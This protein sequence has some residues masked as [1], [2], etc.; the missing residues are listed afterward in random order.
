M[1][2]R[3]NVA[4]ALSVVLL[5]SVV[6][7]THSKPPPPTS[8]GTG[9][10]AS[11]ITIGST[12]PLSGVAEPG[13]NEIARASESYFKYVNAAG[14]VHGR[15]INYVYADDGGSAAKALRQTREQ[16]SK[17]DV[18]AVFNAF[19]TVTHQAAAA[20]LDAHR[21]PDVFVDSACPC[22][23]SVAA[24]PFSFGFQPQG[25]VEGKILGDYV[26]HFFARKKVGY[27]TASDAAGRD[28]ARGLDAVLPHKR[29][30]ARTTYKQHDIKI[31]AQVRKLQASGAQVVIAASIPLFTALLEINALRLHYH[32]QL[33]VSSASADPTT[34]T[35]LLGIVAR[36]A[37]VTVDAGAVLNRVVT[38]TYLPVPTDTSNA[39]IKLFRR[40]HDTYIP[41]LPFDGNVVYG[42]AAAYSFV[43]ALS[44]A[45]EQ[46]TRA[47][48]VAAIEAGLPQGAGL[49]PFAFSADSHRGYTGAQIAVIHRGRL[50]LVGQPRTTDPGDGAVTTFVGK[51]PD[52]P[53]GGIPAT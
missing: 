49:V 52:P 19:G 42:M 14:G 29:V 9:L 31:A 20:F 5:A 18:F 11:T 21:V 25:I 1:K 2:L 13:Y 30:V 8:T 40:I 53:T 22:W 44:A 15:D 41:Q 46:P 4:T 28:F 39:W 35:Q 47:S 48:L 12:Q 38:D 10:T 45:G 3:A 17:D 51:Q 24:H 16:L 6:G 32:P 34:I 50:V 36:Q 43:D 27:F 23:N 33:V 7:C 37:H 26:A